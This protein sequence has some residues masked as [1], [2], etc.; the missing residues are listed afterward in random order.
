VPVRTWSPLEIPSDVSDTEKYWYFGTQR[1]WFIVVRFVAFVGL[2][3]SLSRL[4]LGNPHISVMLIVVL[5]MI[6]VSL[7]GL[8]SSTR[9]R[10]LSQSDHEERVLTWAPSRYPS[11]DIFLPTA[12]EPIEV[13][14]NTYR[15]VAALD[16]PGKITV[17]ALDDAGRGQV[18]DLAD[19]FGF[20]YLCRPDRGHLKK[21][22]NLAFGYRCSDSEVI[23]V[24]DA[25][26]AVRPDFLLELMPYLDDPAVGIAQ[27]PQFFDTHDNDEWV[28]RAA[29]ADQ[30]LFYR[31]VQPSRDALGAPICVG[32]CALYRREALVRAGGFVQIA[33]SEDVH[34]GVAVMHAG[35]T[36]RYVPIILSK[37]LCPEGLAAFVSQQYRWCAGSLSLMVSP[38]FRTMDLSWRQRLCFWSGFGYYLSTAITAFTAFI[39]PIYL[40]WQ[41]PSAIHVRNYLLLLPLFASYQLIVL[42]YRGRW[43]FGVLRIQ[44][45]QSF[46]HAAAIWDTWRG[47]TEEWV[48][49]GAAQRGP[50]GDRVARMM[51]GWLALVQV[52]LWTGIAWDLSRHIVSIR[53]LYPLMAFA[54]FAVYLQVPLILA[55]L[56][57]RPA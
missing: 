29:G 51:A 55:T 52:A 19:R 36:V 44:M 41:N 22:G 40:L 31:W 15:H 35:Y 4:G 39:P 49:T 53:Q 25:D 17:Y 50:L 1:R 7:T 38:H 42:M 2:V 9:P 21:A 23:S 3:I 33:H 57:R 5:M 8:Y 37:G 16:Y 27:S 12:G 11:V 34:T 32:T 47:Y 24:L 43:D 45:A 54:A 13:L 30:E 26:F 10:A 18:A 48:A 28:Q 46:A 14:E 20:R 6:G 56:R